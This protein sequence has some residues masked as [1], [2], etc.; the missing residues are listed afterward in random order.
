MLVLRA[1]VVVVASG[2][3]VPVFI[4]LTPLGELEVSILTA[5]IETGLQL[6]RVAAECRVHISTFASES[7]ASSV[8]ISGTIICESVAFSLMQIFTFFS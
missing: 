6:Y 4:L 7:A 5:V 2:V 3:I 8:H 1:V